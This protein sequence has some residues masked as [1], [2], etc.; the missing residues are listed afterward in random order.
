MN[1]NKLAKKITKIYFIISISTILLL[2][3]LILLT[4]NI[5]DLLL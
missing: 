5:I 4:P 2:L 1:I 3:L